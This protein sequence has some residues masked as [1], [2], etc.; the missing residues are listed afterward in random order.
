VDL[1]VAGHEAPGVR[2][3]AEAEHGIGAIEAGVEDLRD[4]GRSQHAQRR[5]GEQQGQRR[6][7]EQRRES[8]ATG[9]LA[10]RRAGA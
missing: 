9:G 8:E 10:H 6:T 4:L 5:L 7:E 3:V 2:R 1:E